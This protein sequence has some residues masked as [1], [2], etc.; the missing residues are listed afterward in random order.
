MIAATGVSACFAETPSQA[1][2]FRVCGLPVTI[3]ATSPIIDYWAEQAACPVIGIEDLFNE[4]AHRYLGA[5]VIDRTEALVAA[6][7]AVL[8]RVTPEWPFADA[9]SF[10]AFFHY[11]NGSLDSIV[12]R[13]EQVLGACYVLGVTSLVAFRPRRNYQYTGITSLDHAPWGLITQIVPLVAAAHN[14]E[15][16]WIDEPVADPSLF[17]PVRDSPQPAATPIAG[18][19]FSFRARSQRL[20]AWIRRAACRSAGVPATGL[21]SPRPSLGDGPLLITSLFSDLG[22]DVVE[23]WARR[24]GNVIDMNQAFS[25]AGTEDTGAQAA[26]S[27]E[28]LWEKLTQ[29]P[30]VRKLLVWKGVDLWQ[31][32]APWL[33]LVIQEALPPLFRRAETVWNRLM[34]ERAFGN[35]AFVAG[36]WVTD[37]Y[38]VARIARRVGLPTVSY[39]Y[40]GFLGFSLLPK[41]ERFDFAECDYF[42]C[43]GFG[44]EHALRQ[45][46]SQTRWNPAVKRARPVAT[47]V[48]WAAR[49]M[50]SRNEMH[51]KQ[52]RRRVML[53]LNALVGDCR[54]LG[55]VFPPETEY[56]RWTRKVVECLAKWDDIEILIKPPL[57]ARYPQMPNPLLDWIRHRGMSSTSVVADVPLKDC[58]HLADAYILESPSTPL[59]HVA[60]SNK[61]LL[62]YIN[63]QDYLL[64]PDATSALRDRAAVFAQTETEFLAGLER[65]LAAQDWSCDHVN[66]RFMHDYVVGE[67]GATPADRIA[68]FLQSVITQR[69]NAP[70]STSSPE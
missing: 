37:H 13:L 11:A 2:A 26:A 51:L 60:A 40:G 63:P 50:A 68:D 43:G 47:G 1:E 55:F 31:L 39:H 14:L 3:V 59:L 19:V 20:C 36:G 54:D 24:G 64:E 65:F 35:A 15:V 28:L 17:N 67:P 23:C 27:C 4:R 53:V 18:S 41:H 6:I 56:W 29:Q 32:F 16:H 21:E 33:Q 44:A 8:N 57:R 22:D 58:L 45:A 66:D 69:T 42:L 70:C 34:T 46:S 5:A 7:D 30:Q 48:P 49:L 38:V 61:P 10:A 9:V 52:D 25:L 12:L 62:L